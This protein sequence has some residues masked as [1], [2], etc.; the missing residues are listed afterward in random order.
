MTNEATE[1]QIKHIID[2]LDEFHRRCIESGTMNFTEMR[3]FMEPRFAEAGY[4][5]LPPPRGHRTRILIVHHA[6]GA[7]DFITGSA[8]IREI[9][10]IYPEAY[11]VM[12]VSSKAAPLAEC[13]PYIDNLITEN[14]DYNAEDFS[15]MYEWNVR[16]ARNLLEYRFD[17]AF[18]FEYSPES[19]TALL[20]YMVGA[21]ERISTVRTMHQIFAALLTG[22]PQEGQHGY[23]AVESCLSVV[24]CLLRA[25][26]QNRHLEVWT[27]AADRA[28]AHMHLRPE[29]EWYAIGLGASLATKHYPPELYARFINLILKFDPSARF[30]ALG[31]P[32]EEEDGRRLEKAVDSPDSLVNLT[33]SRLGF[34]QSAAVMGLC[35]YYIGNDTA[36]AHM[37]AAHGLP[38]LV[39]NCVAADYSFV[40]NGSDFL[41]RW[42]PYEVPTVIVQPE[43][44]L[45]DCRNSTYYFGCKA[46]KPHCITQITPEHMLEAFQILK[47][48]AARGIKEPYYFVAKN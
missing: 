21:R 20:T 33:G 36:T 31:G 24:E 8:A 18:A 46:N 39:P 5:Q 10:R 34:R 12:T 15:S 3:D 44:G 35:K 11:I 43:H 17:I 30:A 29:G 14:L 28:A 1:E 23:H 27:S 2:S 40:G 45:D 38:S 32:S 42:Y 22:A 48:R 6:A 9:R 26:V 47:D 25:P 7:G 13:C 41:S 4:R 37:A 16:M 19:T